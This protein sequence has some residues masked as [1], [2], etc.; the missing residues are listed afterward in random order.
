MP[1]TDIFDLLEG[2][3]PPS[4]QLRLV[5][6]NVSLHALGIDSMATIGLLAAL[7]DKFGLPIERLAECLS[8]ACTLGMLLDTCRAA[9]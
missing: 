8:R 3:V 9:L 4:V 2:F 5:P 1:S 6:H 7:E